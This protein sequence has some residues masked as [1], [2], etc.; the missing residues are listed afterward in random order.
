MY[1]DR[2]CQSLA[3]FK[4][5]SEQELTQLRADQAAHEHLEAEIHNA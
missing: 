1:R 3:N 5:N 4:K 2:E